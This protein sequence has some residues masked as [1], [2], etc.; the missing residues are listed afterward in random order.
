MQPFAGWPDTGKRKIQKLRIW[1]TDVSCWRNYWK[2][3]LNYCHKIRN[4][5]SLS[6]YF[7]CIS[8]LTLLCTAA[9]CAGSTFFQPAGV[10]RFFCRQTV[11]QIPF[12]LF[13]TAPPDP[14]SLNDNN[15]LYAVDIIQQIFIIL[16]LSFC[17]KLTNCS[18]NF[19]LKSY[20]PNF[21]QIEWQNFRR[22]S[23]CYL[24]NISI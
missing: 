9:V 20:L 11:P 16:L 24:W 19:R 18:E 14:V 5:N 1:I 10:V 4:W 7:N 2:H 23:Y 12:Q 8:A 22:F 3:L 17:A 6:S 15:I 13:M 21:F